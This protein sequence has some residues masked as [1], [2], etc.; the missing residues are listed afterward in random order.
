M[1]LKKA[2]WV[3]MSDITNVVNKG[4]FTSECSSS[5]VHIMYRLKQNRS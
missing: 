2:E 4:S 3:K 1:S 5:Y